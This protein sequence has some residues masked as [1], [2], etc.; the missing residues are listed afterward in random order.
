[1]QAID[2]NDWAIVQKLQ[3]QKQNTMR[4]KY[5]KINIAVMW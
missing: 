5:L 3:V 4:K 2:Y 1:M